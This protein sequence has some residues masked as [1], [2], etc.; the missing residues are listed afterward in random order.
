MPQR[1][2]TFHRLY[3]VPPFVSSSAFANVMINVSV[4][5]PMGGAAYA[6]QKDN[7]LGCSSRITSGGGEVGACFLSNYT[8]VGIFDPGKCYSYS[9]NRFNPTGPAD[10]LNKTCRGTWSEN[11]LNWATMTAADMFIWAMTGG[12]REVDTSADTVLQRARAINNSDWF[13]IKYIA[14]ATG[15]TP[16]SGPIYI[17]NHNAGGYQFKVGTTRGGNQNGTF[18]VRVKVCDPTKGLEEPCK[19]YTSGNNTVNKP[20]GLIQRHA[21]KMRFGVFAYTNDNSQS[22]DGGVLRAPMRYVGKKAMDNSGNLIANAQK[23]INPIIGQ[24]YPNPLGSST[25]KS[26]VIKFINRFHRDG[27]KSYDPISEMFYDVIRYFKTLSPTPEYSRGAP[28]GSFPIYNTWNDPI[29]FYCQKNFVIAINDAN[30]WLDKKLPGT[31]L[32]AIRPESPACLEPSLLT[33]VENHPF[34]IPQST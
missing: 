29:Q 24:I 11:F 14:N 33:T 12:D 4:E 1:F 8:Y 9:S 7:P 6:D 13:P 25:D 18:Y 31:F 22:R 20:E 2:L 26:G 16:W 21:D 3:N 19:G 27:Y 15:Y 23:E 30:P 10:L 34:L 32:P 5:T 28:G 17:T